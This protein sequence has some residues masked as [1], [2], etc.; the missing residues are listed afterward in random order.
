M[1]FII[2]EF[3]PQ[4]LNI[5][6]RLGAI[7][8]TA[9]RPYSLGDRSLATSMTPTADMIDEVAKPQKRLNPPLAETLAIL[10]ALVTGHSPN[11]Y[12][13]VIDLKYVYH[14]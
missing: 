8:A 11:M 4:S 13:S 2:A 14:F 9:T 3:M 12:P 1:Y 6:M 10:I 5:V 7:K